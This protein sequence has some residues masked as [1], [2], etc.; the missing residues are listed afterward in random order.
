VI[1]DIKNRQQQKHEQFI[2][3]DYS[4]LKNTLI[5]Y[6][7]DFMQ[8]IFQ[9]L[10]KESKEELNNL[11]FEFEDTI[12]ILKTPPT[13]LMMLKKNKDLFKEVKEKL[14]IYDARR[15]PIKKKFQFIQGQDQDIGGTEL[16]EEDKQKLDGLDDAW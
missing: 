5:E 6:G 3:F 15:E 7:N 10:I 13:Q 14:H 12:S 11:L 8:Q 4:K 16:T 1:N 9:H 2:I